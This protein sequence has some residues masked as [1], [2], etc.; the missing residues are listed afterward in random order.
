MDTARITRVLAAAALGLLVLL[1]LL[2]LWP[3]GASVPDAVTVTLESGRPGAIAAA[4]ATAA[5]QP[6]PAVA[7]GP[8][9][10]ELPGATRYC[11]T[12]VD[13][14]RRNVPAWVIEDN[15]MAQGM[16]FD[17]KDL[18]CLTAGG[19]PPQVLDFAE[20]NTRRPQPK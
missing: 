19:V 12:I 1:A 4:A 16:K 2:W 20:Q 13:W 18:A 9:P 15:A 14:H 7:E 8:T 3:R 5:P 17:D 6:T 11:T 10:A